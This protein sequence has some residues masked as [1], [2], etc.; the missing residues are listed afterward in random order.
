MKAVCREWSDQYAPLLGKALGVVDREIDDPGKTAEKIRSFDD[1]REYLTVHRNRFEESFRWL[2]P[3][4]GDGME[5]LDVGS[6]GIFSEAFREAFPSVRVSETTTD[7][8]Y[9]LPL[10]A[11]NYDLVICSEVLE[12][13]KDQDGSAVDLFKF[14]GV[15]TLLAECFRILKPGGMLFITTPNVC[16]IA[17][18]YKILH[19]YPPYY[20]LPHVREYTFYEVLE[21]LRSAGFEIARASTRNVWNNLPEQEYLVTAALLH[22]NS[23]N[24]EHRGECTFVIARKP[25]PAGPA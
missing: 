5:I 10:P 2:I 25:R 13:I 21:F 17:N 8:R 14:T 4:I 9:P 19:H 18:I 7:L 16:Q 6:I 24:I 15:H 23:Y 22:A 20:Y 12:H 1:P 11:E 3:N